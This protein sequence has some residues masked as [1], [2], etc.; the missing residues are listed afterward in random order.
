MKVMEE[1]ARVPL[2]LT[3]RAVGSS[4]GQKEFVGDSASSSLDL[5]DVGGDAGTMKPQRIRESGNPLETNILERWTSGTKATTTLV[6][7]TFPCPKT[8]ITPSLSSL[9]AWCLG[10]M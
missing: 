2:F 9:I 5:R 1:R 8:D 10:S 4:T 6:P 7:E 3:Y